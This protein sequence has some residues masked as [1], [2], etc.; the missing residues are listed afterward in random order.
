[1]G[2]FGLKEPNFGTA[3][4]FSGFSD[5]LGMD[6]CGETALTRRRLPLLEHRGKFHCDWQDVQLQVL[7]GHLS[8]MSNPRLNKDNREMLVIDDGLNSRVT[9]DESGIR[10]DRLFVTRIVFG[11]IS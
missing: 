5:M 11:Q 9:I 8:G 10:S 6:S 2:G 4:F 1:M 7:V 3:A